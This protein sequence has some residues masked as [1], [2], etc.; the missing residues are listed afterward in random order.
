MLFVEQHN[1]VEPR[2]A[3]TLPRNLCTYVAQVRA[4]ANSPKL[5]N[6]I[7]PRALPSFHGGS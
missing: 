6:Q 7:D 1:R 3:W 2:V 4:A 5:A